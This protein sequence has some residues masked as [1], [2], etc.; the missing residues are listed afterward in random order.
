MKRDRSGLDKL[1]AFAISDLH[2]DRDFKKKI[3]TIARDELKRY[4]MFHK[5]MQLINKNT[6]VSSLTEKEL[7]NFSDFLIRH[8]ALKD[9]NLDEYYDGEEMKEALN[10]TPVSGYDNSNGVTFKNMAYNGS[11]LKP[12]FLGFISYQDLARMHETRVFSYNLATQ[13]KPATINIRNRFEEVASVNQENVDAICEAV[14]NGTF[15]ENMITLNIRLGKGERYVYKESD[16]S[17][18]IPPDVEIDEL[19]G[20]HR[21]S[22]IHKAWL[23]DK[24][25][26]GMM[27]VIIKHLSTEQ[28]RDFIMQETKGTMNAKEDMVLYDSN[29]NM[30]KLIGEI[31]RYS[32][33]NNIFFN[34]I[35]IDTE[36][37]DPIIFY[38]IFAGEMFNA[39]N[40]TLSKASSRDIFKIRDFIC[41]FYSI[42][43]EVYMEKYEVSSLEEL[44]GSD[45]LNQTFMAGF[46]YPAHTLYINNDGQINPESI[47]KMVNNF[48]MS[49]FEDYIYENNTWNSVVNEYRR[50]WK[51]VNIK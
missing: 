17:L 14:L 39:W 29:G 27:V 12:Q 46:L 36:V 15:E 30:Y 33:A 25:I 37:K 31:N 8:N 22:G 24:D 43:Y 51:S 38:Q 20:H 26:K 42:V 18:W 4:F 45:V 21:I 13:R 6:Q 47:E 35:T 40:E 19:D 50:K 5:V 34:K 9:V 44:K 11:E 32:N 3:T 7:Y 2:N 16:S 23:I 1:V 28:A 41:S 48:D 49:K 10:D